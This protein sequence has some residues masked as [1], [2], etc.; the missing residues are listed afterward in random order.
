MP[1][2]ILLPNHCNMESWAVI[3]CDQYTSDMAYW[4]RV[5]EKAAG[6]PS[7]LHMILPEAELGS[8]NEARINQINETMLD[9]LSNDVFSEYQNAYIYVERTM[10]NGT[11]RQGVVGCVD[12]EAYEYDPDAQLGKDL[13]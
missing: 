4:A 5:K 13:Y 12:L 6:V 7:T 10:K 9:Y 3:A 2:N 1:A 8:H 11:I